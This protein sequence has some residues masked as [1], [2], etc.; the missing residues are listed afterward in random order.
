MDR[1]QKMNKSVIVF[2]TFLIVGLFYASSIKAEEHPLFP[3]GVMGT[4]QVPIYCG[5]GPFDFCLN[6]LLAWVSFWTIPE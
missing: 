1:K 5:D 2:I 3:D 4:Q 6:I